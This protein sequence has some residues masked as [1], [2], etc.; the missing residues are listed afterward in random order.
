MM[1]AL[2]LRR[3]LTSA[4][5]TGFMIKQT[6]CMSLQFCPPLQRPHQ[7]PARRRIINRTNS[8]SEDARSSAAGR[9][10]IDCRLEVLAPSTIVSVVID[11]TCDSTRAASAWKSL[12]AFSSTRY[13]GTCESIDSQELRSNEI[14]KKFDKFHEGITDKKVNSHAEMSSAVD[15]VWSEIAAKRQPR[16]DS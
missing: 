4:V 12:M 14:N 3:R 9:Y 7:S 10:R 16:Y 1:G 11:S 5:E 15:R 8:S 2:L 13:R 6:N